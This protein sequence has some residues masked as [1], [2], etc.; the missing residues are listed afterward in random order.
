MS[1]PSD[2]ETIRAILDNTRN[3]VDPS[4]P[5]TSPS[6]SGYSSPRA[7]ST[8]PPPRGVNERPGSPLSLMSRIEPVYPPANFSPTRNGG[9]SSDSESRVRRQSAHTN[10]AHKSLE[11]R[12]PRPRRQQPI[13]ITTGAASRSPESSPTRGPL[14]LETKESISNIIK[15][16]LKPYYKS[17]RIT[18]DQ[19]TSINRDLS[20]RLYKEVSPDEVLN[21][22][23][24]QRCERMA[25]KEVAK[26]VAE[27][28]DVE[29]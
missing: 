4:S 11:I 17:G 27:V 9:D 15:S 23:A 26:A 19:Y 14:T 13:T 1:T 21:D 22:D 16:A 10:G 20:R 7:L 3:G 24:R 5:A 2:D 8:T 29:A 18:A 28:K 6:P 12:Q 25:T